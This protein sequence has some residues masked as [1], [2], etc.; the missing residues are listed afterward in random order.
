MAFAGAVAKG[1]PLAARANVTTFGPLLS[2][3]GT[4]KQYAITITHTKN[5]AVKIKSNVYIKLEKLVIRYLDL[6][7]KKSPF[8]SNVTSA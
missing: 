6:R 3:L 5:I 2:P 7:F 8:S 4:L 1:R